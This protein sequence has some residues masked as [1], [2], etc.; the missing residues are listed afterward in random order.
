[1]ESPNSSPSSRK[2]RLSDFNK[3]L[4][5][6]QSAL[7]LDNWT[8]GLRWSDFEG[9][10]SIVPASIDY[11]CLTKEAMVSVASPEYEQMFTY[12]GH[13]Y[14]PNRLMLHELLHLVVEPIAPKGGVDDVEEGVV[15]HLMQAFLRLT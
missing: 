9:R 3:A 14:D 13:T 2:A 8:I 4:R 12:P 5:K 11:D 10:S 6:W 7:L 1:M 15:N